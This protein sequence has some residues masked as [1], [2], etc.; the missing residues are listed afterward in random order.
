MRLRLSG[1]EKYYWPLNIIGDDNNNDDDDDD[2]GRV[3]L[4]FRPELQPDQ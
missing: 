1:D 4:R 2:A 3:F